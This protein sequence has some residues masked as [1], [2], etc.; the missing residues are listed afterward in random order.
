MSRSNR[1]SNQQSGGDATKS[2]LVEQGIEWITNPRHASIVASVAIVGA[3]LTYFAYH[4]W[5]EEQL[6]NPDRRT[7]FGRRA[8]QFMQKS[9]TVH[10]RHS[11]ENLKGVLQLPLD[12]S[13]SI[14]EV[15]LLRS[16]PG[17]CLRVFRLDYQIGFGIGDGL[18]MLSK[19][20]PSNKLIGLDLSHAMVEE[21][22]AT[23]VPKFDGRLQVAQADVCRGLGLAPDSCGLIYNMN[24]VYFW[25]DLDAAVQVLRAPLLQGGSCI[26]VMKPACVVSAQCDAKP[27]PHQHHRANTQHLILAV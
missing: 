2:T 5:L 27:P 12:E 6:A 8:I 7:F 19:E 3:G 4:K 21:A 22:Q 26:T 17:M 16:S 20:F 9:N 23:L 15:R 14:A 18:Q 25:E 13:M 10:M 1:S 24:C 11:I